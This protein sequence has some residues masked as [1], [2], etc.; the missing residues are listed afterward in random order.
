MSLPTVRLLRLQAK[1]ES[2]AF[3]G[4]IAL[5]VGPQYAKTVVTLIYIGSQREILSQ[6]VWEPT[7][8]SE[9]VE[10]TGQSLHGLNASDRDPCHAAS[11]Q[12]QQLTATVP[13]AVIIHC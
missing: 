3:P 5:Q 6:H 13:P 12:H 7:M 9:L 10:I 4:S 8:G 2:Q 11:Q 1:Q